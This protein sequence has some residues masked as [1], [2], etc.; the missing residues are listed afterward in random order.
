M[1]ELTNPSIIHEAEYTHRIHT[2]VE[3]WCASNLHRGRITSYDG[4]LLRYYYAMNPDAAGTIMVLHGFCE[5]IG[6]YRE[7]LYT[8]YHA[9]Y[10]VFFYEQRGHGDSAREIRNNEFVYVRSFDKYVE[11]LKWFMDKKVLPTVAMRKTEAEMESHPLFLF[12]HSMGGAVASLFLEE[13]PEYFDAAILSSPMH[14]M[15]VKDFKPW[16]VRLVTDSARLL[17]LDKRPAPG[18]TGFD[19][20]EAYETSCSLSPARFAYIL[21][22]RRSH[23]QYQTGGATVSWVGSGLRAGEQILKNAGKIDIPILLLQAQ[24]DDL[25][26]TTAHQEFAE[27]TRDT[28]I[29]LFEGA[30]HEIMNGTDEMV[31]RF[32]GEIFSFLREQA[33]KL[34]L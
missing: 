32:Y 14:R 19:P 15:T 21:D 2:E 9:G 31:D 11:D 34:S 7:L 6:K 3:P 12:G 25:V 28:R 29:V 20:N 4:K 22:L 27:K 33:E 16:Q 23:P 26:D 18:Q 30:K 5:F 10:N 13:Y 1:K 24:L 8:F 17:H